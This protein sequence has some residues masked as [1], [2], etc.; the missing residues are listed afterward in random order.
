MKN[1][2]ASCPAVAVRPSRR[3]RKARVAASTAGPQSTPAAKLWA[4]RAALLSVLVAT[5]F[6]AY[7]ACLWG[8]FLF[9]DFVLPFASPFAVQMPLLTWLGGVRPAL[10]LTYWFNY[11][12]SASTY[13][14]H[15]TNVALHSLNALLV[16]AICERLFRLCLADSGRVFVVSALSCSLFLLHPLQSESVAYITGRSEVLSATFLLLAWFLH[17]RRAGSPTTAWQACAIL[18]LFAL[19]AAA[20]EQAV[21]TIPAILLL[22]DWTVRKASMWAELRASKRLYIPL[23]FGVAIGAVWVGRV[24]LASQSAGTSTGVS[25]LDYLLT[26]SR[27][28]LVYLRLFLIPIGQNVDRDFPLSHTPFEHGAVFALAAI[29][30][31]SVLMLRQA[32]LPRYGWFLFLAFLAPTSSVVPL[33]D[34]FAEHRMY[35][36]IAGLCI[37]LGASLASSRIPARRL[38]MVCAV[39]SIVAFVA[40]ARRTAIWSDGIVFWQDV[41]VKSPQ[42]ARGYQHLTHMY[43][44]AGRCKEAIS[45]LETV[46][47]LASRDYF[48]LLNWADA[49][50]C[51][52]DR[53]AALRKLQEAARLESTA[54]VYGQMGRILIEE[55]RVNEARAAFA[56]ALAKEP[57][58]TDLA[59]IYRGNLALLANDH[60]GALDAV[61]RALSLNPWC[62]EAAWLLRLIRLSAIPDRSAAASNQPRG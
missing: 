49:Y 24:L 16:F 39:C 32:R 61:Q 6:Q 37:G 53:S 40:T 36:P 60:T 57:P 45:R 13:G 62:P 8:P 33:S 41:V 28:I 20:K 54:D 58:G 1:F 15:L 30:V 47:G 38:A 51:A 29:V 25:S 42:K 17:V 35:L 19:A 56:E 48:I 11:Q 3:M 14:Y 12:T 4:I 27:A 9:D 52:G 7:S 46:D 22:T 21:A 10:M 55:G 44:A 26:E 34:P 5:G 18:V 2:R 31:V 43:V 23:C 59:Q 50:I